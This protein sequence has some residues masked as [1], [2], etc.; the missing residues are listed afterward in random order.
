[1]VGLYSLHSRGILHRDIKPSNLLIDHKGHLLISDFGLS[2]M[3]SMTTYGAPPPYCIGTMK[4][5]SSAPYLVKGFSGTI[6][7][8]APE[9]LLEGQCGFGAD[10]WAAGITLFQMLTGKVI[11]ARCIVLSHADGRNSK[12]PWFHPDEVQMAEKICF[13]PLPRG[14]IHSFAWMLLFRVGNTHSLLKRG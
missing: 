14:G 3:F 2:Q 9:V 6:D 13:A 1:M 4:H 5:L 11:V 10:Y 7:Y 8:M 12:V